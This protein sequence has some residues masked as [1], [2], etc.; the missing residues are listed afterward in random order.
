MTGQSGRAA[1]YL[2]DCPDYGEE[3]VA[4]AL[5]SALSALGGWEALLPEKA[6]RILIKPNLLTRADPERAVTTHPAVFSAVC[7]S[8]KQAGYGNLFFGDSPG[9]PHPGAERIAEECGITAAAAPFGAVQ[10]DFS[11]GREYPFPGGRTA[12]SFIIANGVLSCDRIVNVCKLK[13]HMLERM[14]GAQKN[15]F[16]IVYGLNKGACHVKYPNAADFA[17]MLADLNRAFPPVL[18]VMD[19]VD[20]MEGNGPHNGT[21]KHL[22]KLL[23][24]TDP[25]ALDVVA[26]SL[27]A[28][29]PALVPTN[30][31]G[32]MA[33]VGT[34]DPACID[35]FADGERLTPGEVRERYG[36]ETF[37]VYRGKAD[38]G[39]VRQLRFLSP[40]LKKRPRIDPDRCVACG[41][42]VRSC[43][44]EPKAL[45]VPE[46]GRVPVYDYKRCIRCFCC[47]E[48]C[49]H[50]AISVKTTLLARLVDRN[51]K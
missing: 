34:D 29:D 31:R 32:A 46:G 9:A 20:A 44:L 22:G 10:A 51:L 2:I 49:P 50:G 26:C 42:C 13:T 27:I 40:L 11:G 3:T 15:L 37:D 18:H 23:V 30:R 24:S 8:L 41:V 17:G 16:G 33:G 7:A 45:A 25:V 14:T 48:M 28:L 4:K 19:A 1:V 36:D 47:Q 39:N 43:P 35:V 12:K 6:E 21:K 38:R 5:A